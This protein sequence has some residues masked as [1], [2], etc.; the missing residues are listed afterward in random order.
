MLNPIK[1]N[2]TISDYVIKFPTGLGR[3][4][5]KIVDILSGRSVEAVFG[6]NKAAC[7][8]SISYH[9]SLDVLPPLAKKLDTSVLMTA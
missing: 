1:V 3:K 2:E 6:K 5:K 9:D 4:T 8:E 7:Q